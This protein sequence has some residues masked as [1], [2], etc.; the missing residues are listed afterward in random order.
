MEYNV[1]LKNNKIY[2]GAERKIGITV[3]S[4]DYILKFRKKTRFGISRVQNH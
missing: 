1:Y 2:S 4:E 3:G